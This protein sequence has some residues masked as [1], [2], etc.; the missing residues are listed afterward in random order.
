MWSN[1]DSADRNQTSNKGV[2]PFSGGQ[3]TW[4]APNKGCCSYSDRSLVVW[5]KKYQAQK[6][7][8]T[9]TCSPTT[10]SSH[11]A[12]RVN[13]TEKCYS[14]AVTPNLC[15]PAWVSLSLSQLLNSPDTKNIWFISA[16]SN[17]PICGESCNQV[18]SSLPWDLQHTPCS[19]KSQI[20]LL[21]TARHPL[22]A[23][24]DTQGNHSVT[25]LTWHTY[26]FNF[27]LSMR[28]SKPHSEAEH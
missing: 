17:T 28:N 21:E 11:P 20:S 6:Q 19:E 4:Q 16:S 2:V 13:P 10:I 7:R 27:L 24:Q 12:R 8:Q 25:Q 1:R 26:S 9:D 14:S 18:D 15:S 22:W 5:L 3:Q 23:A